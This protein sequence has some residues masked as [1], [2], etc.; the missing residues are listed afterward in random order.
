MTESEKIVQARAQHDS[1]ASF[2]FTRADIGIR[3]QRYKTAA[4]APLI[5]QTM[6][7]SPWGIPVVNR[8]V[9]G[10]EMQVHASTKSSETAANPP[11]CAPIRVDICTAIIG[12][13]RIL[14]CFDLEFS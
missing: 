4:H 8:V 10:T 7:R 14:L 5:F 1:I 9:E 3:Y 2:V 6:A 11:C 12:E 13:K